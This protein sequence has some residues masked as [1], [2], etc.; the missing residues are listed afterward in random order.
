M[1][2]K[3]GAPSEEQGT[4]SAPPDRAKAAA[5]LLRLENKYRNGLLTESEGELW[6]EMATRLFAETRQG[7]RRKSF[8]LPCDLRGHAITRDEDLFQCQVTEL[9]HLGMAFAAVPARS[10]QLGDDVIIKDLVFDG[11]STALDLRCEV[12]T[13]GGVGREARYGLTFSESSPSV[14]TRYFERIYYPVYIRY[15]EIIAGRRS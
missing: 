15:L 9:S 13:S 12:V 8:R 3:G 7:K 11:D 2:S 5:E 4:G 6:N 14:S 10:F 1:A